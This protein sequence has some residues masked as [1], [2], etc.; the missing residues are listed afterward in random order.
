[1]F[2][3]FNSEDSVCLDDSED[4]V[5]K[6]SQVVKDKLMKSI[7]KRVNVWVLENIVVSTVLKL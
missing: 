3:I 5:R 1:M 4:R 7:D 6:A 2:P